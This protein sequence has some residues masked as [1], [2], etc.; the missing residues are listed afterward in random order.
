MENTIINLGLEQD[1]MELIEN[2][3]VLIKAISAIFIQLSNYTSYISDKVALSIRGIESQTEENYLIELYLTSETTIASVIE[4]VSDKLEKNISDCNSVKL[5]IVWFVEGETNKYYI[6]LDIE[7]ST[8]LPVFKCNKEDF[9]YLVFKNAVAHFHTIYNYIVEN[10]LCTLFEI[11]YLSESEYAQIETFA[12]SKI[13][14]ISEKPYLSSIFE[15]IADKYPDQHAICI[16]NSSLTYCQLDKRA[17][18]LAHYLRSTGIK[19]G[20]FVGILLKRSMELYVSILGIIKAGAVYVP[21]DVS[22][23]EDRINYILNDSK[24][25]CLLTTSS[26]ESSFSTFKGRVL[27]FE[28]ELVHIWDDSTTETRLTPQLTP[29]SP[30][31]TIYTSGSTGRPKGVVISH[32]AAYNLIKAE[33]E[34]YQMN[35]NDRVAQTFSP[36]FDASV[37]EIWMA[38]ASGA[39]LYPVCESFMRS[40]ADLCTFAENNKISAL[41]T[42]PTMLSM[43]SERLDHLKLL[44][45]GGENCPTEL[46]AKWHSPNLRI[47]NT[48][49]PTEATV[50]TSFDVFNPNSKITIGRPLTNY[51]CFILNSGLQQVP[52]GVAGELCIGGLSLASE[53]INN[54][55]LT[56]AK[57]V[58]PSF[59]I[60]TPFPQ[61]IYRSG[62][63]ARFN[64]EGKIEFLGRIDSQV[65][66]RGYRI[67]LAE[68]ESQLMSYPTI[69][70]AIVAVKED[71][72]KVQR[73][74]AYIILKD[75]NYIFDENAV[76]SALKEKMASY[77]VPAVFLVLTEF[78]TLPSGKVDKKKLPDLEVTNVDINRTI[79]QPK[80]EAEK[81]ILEIWKRYFAPNEVSITDDFFELGGHSLLASM[82]ISDL[83]RVKGYE[84]ISVQDIYKYPT[85]ETLALHCAELGKTQ[86]GSNVKKE[87]QVEPVSRKTYLT[88]TSLQVVSFY[89]IFLVSTTGLISPF[90]IERIVPSITPY[91]LIFYSSIFVVSTI[92]A[93]IIVSILLKWLLIGKFKEGVYPLWGGYYFRF[94]LVKKFVDLVPALLFAGTPFINFYYRLLGA[95]IGKNVYLSCDRIRIFDLITI[96]DNSSIAK[97][98]HL[99]GYE[100]KDGALII[101]QINIGK[102]CYVGTRSVVSHGTR[103]EDN[104]T[105]GELS[106][107]PNDF[108]I[109]ESENWEGSP[110]CY[111]E[112]SK[113]ENFTT[114]KKLK[115][116]P[117]PIYLAVQF[118]GVLVLI[119]YP[120]VLTVPFALCYYE[121]DLNFGFHRALA[122]TLPFSA[123]YIV[124]YCLFVSAIKWT[125][126][127]KIEE[128][129]VSI[130]SFRYITK[131]FVDT[132][133]HFTLLSFKFMYATIY[134]PTWLRL[135]GAK[136][137]KAAEI[138][139]VN[140]I[141]ADILT[142]GKGS[143][144]ADSVSVGA[145][146]VRNGIMYIRKTVIGDKT[147][148]GNSAVLACGD[149][150]G[151]DSLIGVLSVPPKNPEPSQWNGASWLGSPPMFLP[152]RQESER[153]D[154]KYTFNPSF[155]LYFKRGFIEFFKVTLPF[156]FISIII[157]LF[158]KLIYDVLEIEDFNT[159]IFL[160]PLIFVG[161][162]LTTPF[163][164]LLFKKI[165]IGKYQQKNK[166]LWSW[167]VW[168]NELVNSLCESMVYPLLINLL[169]GTPFASWFFRMMGC[170]IGKNV[171]METTEIT[172]FDL[173]TIGD[174]ACLNYLSTIQTHLFEDRVMKM[175]YLKVG[176]DCTVGAMSVVLYDSV[177]EDKSTIDPLSLVMKGET[178][179]ENTHWVG[180]PVKFI[181]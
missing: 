75:V 100:V 141:S 70:N 99:L 33:D 65:K 177:M 153:F 28:H 36:A 24:S 67:E 119:F 97:E 135:M 173:V 170:E 4:S 40:G 165:L 180:S 61:R 138:S 161:L 60:K 111:V 140:Q 6:T 128:D 53:Y 17:N 133:M 91:S 106:L 59:E 127:G 64:A 112:T 171:Y 174:N 148:I 143:F 15:E 131:W 147:F 86:Q 38:F 63:L 29:N 157:L 9:Y 55:E 94:W 95:K 25:L 124:C 89:L 88:T 46:L 125:I 96:G 8:L 162:T 69:K 42:V 58:N 56:N 103:M 72:F 108:T 31:Y 19:E 41:S 52:I 80:S 132:V 105:L 20:D 12:Y 79:I 114:T 98:A 43:M 44:I 118:I 47:I 178:L 3:N 2:T 48:Y 149:K 93:L 68:I 136:V 30:V 142:I 144:L 71:N 49:G 120:L 151:N 126:V 160:A 10:K 32:S 73:L 85:I 66:L 159:T 92:I 158:Y 78:P 50:V 181:G 11:P 122:A 16:D 104:S 13:E 54:Q 90:A 145:P 176:N 21:M 130:Y 150:V 84:K 101:G 134:T 102:N 35:T 146:L 107:L 51:S 163:I 7:N 76:K 45:L 154:E 175:S 62:D 14:V 5:D 27:R 18:Q 82:V 139:T 37:E 166:P 113:M 115:S 121:I 152:Q 168:K 74:V 26:L 87:I 22:Y 116:L 81:L 109:P 156:T 23:P 169:L 167:F 34:L 179:P 77:M 83:R 117:Y 129:E 172:E 137:G 39:T 1:N 164:A 110:A 123:I 155:D 57:F